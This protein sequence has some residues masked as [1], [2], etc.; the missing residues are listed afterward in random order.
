MCTRARAAWFTA[1][2]FGAV[3]CS[4][5]VGEARFSIEFDGGAVETTDVDF[6]FAPRAKRV[7]RVVMVTNVGPGALLVD[8]FTKEGEGPAIQVGAVSEPDAVFGVDLEPMT[9]QP[10]DS[11]PLTF[12]FQPPAEPSSPAA[13]YAVTLTTSA[14]NVAASTPPSRLT[15]MGRTGLLI[16]CEFPTRLDFG[17]VARGDTLEQSLVLKNPRTQSRQARISDLQHASSDAAFTL[18]ADSPRGD[19]TLAPGGE[20]T[21][22]FVF[23][24]TDLR[25][26]AATVTVSPGD[27]C[28][29]F[30]M[31]LVGTGVDATLTSSPAGGLDFGYVEE[32][33]PVTSE[34]IFFNRAFRP[35]QLRDLATREGAGLSNLY[36]VVSA[37][38]GDVT[39]LTVPAGRRDAQTDD[40]EPGVARVIVR[41]EPLGAGPRHATLVA[42]TD[43]RS[44]PA[45]VVPLRGVAGGPDIDVRPAPTLSLG[46]IAFFQGAGASATGR[47][48]VRNVGTAPP[49]PDPQENLRLGAR[50]TGQPLWTVTPKNAESALDE[51]CV[52]TF[53]AVS[54]TCLHGVPGYDPAVGL[55]A[56]G[57]ASTLELPVRVQ[58]KNLVTNAVTGN[59]EWEVALFSN[60]LDEP[61]V[62]ITVTAR[63]VMLPPCQY[64]LTPSSL[65]FGPVPAPSTRDL[66]FRVC[67]VAPATATGNVCILSSVALGAGSHPTFSLPSGPIVQN[68][69]AP[70]QCE[71]IR[72]RAWPMSPPSSAMT[73]TG[74]VVFTLSSDD[75]VSANVRVPVTAVLVP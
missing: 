55:V 51:I 35:V 52:G 14:R 21:V 37:N 12:F 20:A 41:F 60:D 15:L 31:R 36:R 18:R 43:L 39:R 7:E 4:S 42:T 17:A 22:T 34:L 8:G 68:E 38:P 9:L 67:N 64:T 27:G 19:L 50:G 25:D 61:E 44:Q 33:L 45:L 26:S 11:R 32:G 57:A 10:G 3:G 54:G 28:P 23:A 2:L 6:G 66:T 56:G 65:D 5:V 1:V 13:S 24:P 70:Q 71:T 53:D 30:T 72:V 49:V 48:V 74:S 69:L 40:I 59:K 62:R 75:P 46:R 63:P 58:P 73:V 47:L 29:E 16:D